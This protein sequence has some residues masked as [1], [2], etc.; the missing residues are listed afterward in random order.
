MVSDVVNSK[1]RRD[2]RSEEMS[3]LRRS[4]SKRRSRFDRLTVDREDMG[5]R[6]MFLM[7]EKAKIKKAHSNGSRIR[8]RSAEDR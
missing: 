4:Q 7:N 8:R 1:K 2:I 5:I 3:I 6:W